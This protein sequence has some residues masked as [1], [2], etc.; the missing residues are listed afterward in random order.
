MLW[1]KKYH[2]GLTNNLNL[3]NEIGGGAF[4]D[5]VNGDTLFVLWAK[6][7]TDE[8][9][10][11][12]ASYSFPQTFGIGVVEKKNWDYSVTEEVS[13]I[14]AQNIQL[15]GDPVFLKGFIDPSIINTT[16]VDLTKE[17]WI[18]PNPFTEFFKVRFALE[19]EADVELEIFDEKGVMVY[20]ALKNE[21]GIGEHDFLVEDAPYFA[22]G[23]YFGRLTIDG[24]RPWKFKVLKV[25][26]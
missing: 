7:K 13:Y 9:E 25:E 8:S 21:L 16:P 3:P 11:S 2:Q 17:P 4:T 18:Q 5:E 24:K 20:E 15:T 26:E 19:K 6:T 1:G 14:N 12:T 22:S 23:I 10:V